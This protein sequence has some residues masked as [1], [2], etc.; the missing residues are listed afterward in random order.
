M[1]TEQLESS[2]PNGSKTHW[3]VA[4]FKPA[5]ILH[6]WLKQQQ[7]QISVWCCAIPMS[8]PRQRLFPCKDTRT[9]PTIS[10]DLYTNNYRYHMI[11]CTKETRHNNN[12][13][14]LTT[15]TRLRYTPTKTKVMVFPTTVT[16]IK[17]YNKIRFQHTV[18]EALAL[19]YKTK[20]HH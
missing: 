9:V 2:L 16:T 3:L 6:H 18:P 7:H 11:M 14:I 15:F 1:D 8:T 4:T 13:N 12:R 17:S 10:S 19:A 5:S 20:Q